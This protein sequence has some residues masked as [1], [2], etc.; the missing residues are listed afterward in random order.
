[1]ITFDYPF[2]KIVSDR[3]DLF[4]IKNSSFYIGTNS[5]LTEIAYLFNIP[6]LLHNMNL[7]FEGYPRKKWIE[8]SKKYLFR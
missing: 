1:M 4:F 5:G 7:M 8:V 6:V 3:N 2:S